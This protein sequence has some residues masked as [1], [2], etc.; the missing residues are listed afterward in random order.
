VRPVRG[1][2]GKK[3]RK[4]PKKALLVIDMLNDFIDPAGTLYC[5]ESS[6]RIIP[7]IRS[8]VADFLKQDHLVVYL[9]DAHAPDDKEFEIFAPHAVKDTWGGKVI[10]ELA[11]PEGAVTVD[12][13]RFS[14]LYGNDLARILAST[15]PEEVWVAGVVTSICV[16]D[17]AGD[18]R[19]RDYSVVIPV[20]AV[21]DFDPE[22][23]D[24][25]LRRMKRV[26]GAR[27]VSSSA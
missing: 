26:Y 22:F 6:R 18:L 12:K 8:L 19:N 11:P 16:M 27:L 24:F 21:A 13:T 17:T 10:A 1:L 20:D 2:V 25:A 5:G 4:M 7:V 14:G 15:G 3:E 23:H 9:R